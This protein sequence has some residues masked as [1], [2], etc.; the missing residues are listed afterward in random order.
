MTRSRSRSDRP[1]PP[2]YPVWPLAWHR[3]SRG[4]PGAVWTGARWKCPPFGP[5]DVVVAAAGVVDRT[6]RAADVVSTWLPWWER[7]RPADA[8]RPHEHGPR[9][10]LHVRGDEQGLR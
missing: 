2:G 1:V 8:P 3:C 10:I 9:V 6:R 5:G 7:D 4:A